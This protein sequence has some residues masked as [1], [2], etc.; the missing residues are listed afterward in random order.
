[1]LV[2]LGDLAGGPQ[3]Q[4]RRIADRDRARFGARREI[5]HAQ[6]P[7]EDHVRPQAVAGQ[8]ERAEL[9][10]QRKAERLLGTVDGGRRSGRRRRARL[11][12]QAHHGVDEIAPASPRPVHAVSLVERRDEGG[13][14]VPRPV[15]LD[16][17]YARHQQGSDV[18]AGGQRRGVRLRDL[19]GDLRPALQRLGGGLRV[20]GGRRVFGVR[21][22]RTLPP[23]AWRQGIALGQ[24]LL[25]GLLL[26][27][28]VERGQLL[29]PV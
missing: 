11:A 27:V 6:Q 17:Q 13:G 18:P 23:P 22:R 5:R 24:D 25:V 14:V 4:R 28:E 12:A 8:Q 16:R 15:G 29:C 9:V 3:R 19:P 7:R 2:V 1:Q 20:A 10:G 21:G 26:G